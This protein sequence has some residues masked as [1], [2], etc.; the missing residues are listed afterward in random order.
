MSSVFW[1]SSSLAMSTRNRIT[2]NAE[3]KCNACCWAEEKK[4]LDSDKVTKT[5]HKL[6]KLLDKLANKIVKAIETKQ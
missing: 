3:G 5:E 2:F 4:I 1:C 6:I